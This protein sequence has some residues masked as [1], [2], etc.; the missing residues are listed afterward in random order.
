M[1]A[2]VDEML[3]SKFKPGY[4]RKLLLEKHN[5]RSHLVPS[6]RQISTRRATLARAKIKE[7]PP[8]TTQE[9]E[10]CVWLFTTGS[11]ASKA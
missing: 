5:G 2:S 11:E 8:M 9:M 6:T 7:N 4:I 1:M 10:V 3:G